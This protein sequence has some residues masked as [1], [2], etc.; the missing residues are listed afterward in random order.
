MLLKSFQEIE[1]D[2][3]IETEAETNVEIVVLGRFVGANNHCKVWKTLLLKTIQ[4]FSFK[5]L[6]KPR[7]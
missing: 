6:A 2:P 1:T 7:A 3:E 4:R 5:K